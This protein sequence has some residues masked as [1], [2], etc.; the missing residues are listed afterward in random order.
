MQY[1]QVPAVSGQHFAQPAYPA[2]PL[3]TAE[4]SPPVEQL[5]HNLEHGYTIAWYTSALPEDQVADL[6]A[7]VE[8]MRR[9]E[10]TQQGKF[11]A[12]PWDESRG[13]LP[14]DASLALAH[15]GAEDGALQYCGGVSG[16]VFE[17]FVTSHPAD[18]SPEPTAA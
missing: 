16:Q 12:A 15:W 6:Q 18:D 4:D 8:A 5:V 9:D 17:D 3:Y 13:A 1:D 11:I 7:A 10:A 2:A 14:G